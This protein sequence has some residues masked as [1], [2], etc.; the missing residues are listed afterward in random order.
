M[1]YATVVGD[2][3]A[4]TANAAAEHPQ[5]QGKIFQHILFVNLGEVV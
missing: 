5:R 2:N 4:T 3:T 1:A